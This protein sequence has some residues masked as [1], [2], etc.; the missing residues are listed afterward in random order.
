MHCVAY[1]LPV[2]CD[3]AYSMTD[4]DWVCSIAAICKVNEAPEILTPHFQKHWTVQ[5]MAAVFP[6]GFESLV[7][8]LVEDLFTN[9][10]NG[11]RRFSRP[12]AW[13]PY[14]GLFNICGSR[15][16]R[17]VEGQIAQYAYCTGMNS[18]L[19]Q[20]R[21]SKSHCHA[22]FNKSFVIWRHRFII[23]LFDVEHC[24]YT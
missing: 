13:A 16:S 6:L 21:G 8:P 7:R 18:V 9:L 11:S 17:F 19:S 2:K 1:I 14:A 24:R 10:A 22:V 20:R 5:Q 3:V 23:V 12:P 15:P 4:T